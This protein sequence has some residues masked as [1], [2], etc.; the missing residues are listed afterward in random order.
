MLQFI[1]E[2][3]PQILLTTGGVFAVVAGIGSC[4]QQKKAG[5][6][7]DEQRTR[8]EDLTKENNSLSIEIKDRTIEFAKLQE[9]YTN[10]ALGDKSFPILVLT[11]NMTKEYFQATLKNMNEFPIYRCRVQF[12]DFPD[13][14]G[15]DGSLEFN[16][17]GPFTE[18]RSNRN[19]IPIADKSTKKYIIELF[20][21]S[22]RYIQCYML[23]YVKGQWAS[24]WYIAKVNGKEVQKPIPGKSGLSTNEIEYEYE[25]KNTHYDSDKFLR[26]DFQ[27]FEDFYLEVCPSKYYKPATEKPME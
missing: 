22:A 27:E 5:K 23:K 9:K 18:M 16:T 2:N 6:K 19:V 25:P 4:V 11:E 10:F 12:P 1:I 17:L 21:P 8:I 14:N 24:A 20:T 13:A 15:I 3:W 7:Q 26:T